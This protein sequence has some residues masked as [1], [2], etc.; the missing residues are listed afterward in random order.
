[1]KDDNVIN[2]LAVGM[3]L[4]AFFVAFVLAFTAA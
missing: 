2:Y 3:V 1:M 4:V